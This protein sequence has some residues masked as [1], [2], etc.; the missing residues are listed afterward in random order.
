MTYIKDPDEKL[1]YQVDWS[2]HL[3]AA[4]TIS[5]VTWTVQTG[6][7]KSSSPAASNTTTTATVWLEAGTAGESYDVACRITTNQN[8]VIE[9]TFTVRVDNR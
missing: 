5:S 7:T 9:R 3:A 1:D 4:E 8:R 2:T 6:L